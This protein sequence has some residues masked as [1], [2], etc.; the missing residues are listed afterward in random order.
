MFWT[1]TL[2]IYPAPKLWDPLEIRISMMTHFSMRHICQLHSTLIGKSKNGPCHCGWIQPW[3]WASFGPQMHYSWAPYQESTMTLW[4][5]I[6]PCVCWPSEG[7][8]SLLQHCTRKHYEKH[9]FYPSA[10][11]AGG[12]LSSRSG[13]VGGRLPNLWN[14]YLCNRLMDF[15]RSKFCE[16]VWACSCAPSWSFVHLPHMGLPIGQKLVKFGTNWVQT[17]RNA[18]LW[19]R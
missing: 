3:K 9:V 17:L 19:N 15:L 12:V 18:Y 11:R 13:R 7:G 16:I 4:L 2:W 10:L 1:L 6:Y 8:I 5:T 14:P